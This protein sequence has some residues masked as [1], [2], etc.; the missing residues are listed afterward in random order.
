MLHQGYIKGQVV[1]LN[2]A[3][4]S[5]T[6]GA[7]VG[8]VTSAEFDLRGVNALAF[9]G[10]FDC[11]A[12]HLLVGLQFKDPAGNWSY[13]GWF[14]NQAGVTVSNGIV[15]HTSAI[16]AVGRTQYWGGVDGGA[17]NVVYLPSITGRLVLFNNGG[18]IN[19][20]DLFLQIIRS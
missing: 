1:E 11:T 12:A 2:A 5:I 14:F 18:T 15:M 10:T 19:I 20:D 3:D 17:A 6:P 13:L 7:L 9:R 4:L 8:T 16:G